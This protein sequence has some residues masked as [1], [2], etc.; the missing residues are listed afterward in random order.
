VPLLTQ[1]A[2]RLL[3]DLGRPRACSG[4]RDF[5]GIALSRV[6][7]SRFDAP[8][9]APHWGRW[10]VREGAVSDDGIVRTT[11][12]GGLQA[13]AVR[14]VRQHLTDLRGTGVTDAA[15]VVLDNRTGSVLAYVGS[16]G[17]L[18]DA[19]AVDHARALRQ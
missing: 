11:L 8:G 12:D 13:M 9:L 15:V 5:V 3:R 1:R 16:S 4:L 7:R 6:R 17:A 14:S 10:L 2:C 19:W 18:S